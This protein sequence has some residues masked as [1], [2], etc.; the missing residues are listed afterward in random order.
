MTPDFVSP[1]R[2]A[3]PID[4]GKDTRNYSQAKLLGI[5]K[6]RLRLEAFTHPAARYDN[7]KIRARGEA[8]WA[9]RRAEEKKER[10]SQ[11]L[12]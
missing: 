11:G 7:E 1:A 8:Y 3:V 6:R 4:N 5:S 9:I 10:E 12:R 2:K